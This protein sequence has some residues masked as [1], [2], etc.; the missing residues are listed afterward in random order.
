MK[1]HTI[2]CSIVF[3]SFVSGESFDCKLPSAAE[4]LADNF[5]TY[6]LRNARGIN[7]P[8]NKLVVTDHTIKILKNV[9][10]ET[11]PELRKGNSTKTISKSYFS[12]SKYIFEL[13]QFPTYII[14]AVVGRNN[15]LL[16]KYRDNKTKAHAVLIK[17]NLRHLIVP[18]AQIIH[19]KDT[20]GDFWTIIIE[21]KA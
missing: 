9:L 15:G 20:H 21:E 5:A 4:I 11:L 7:T 13:D 18:A 3:V 6:H 1:L 16:T 10:K 12:L 17:N 14:K 8:H 2:L 19:L